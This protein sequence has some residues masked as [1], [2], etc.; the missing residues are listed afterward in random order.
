MNILNIQKPMCNQKKGLTV[1]SSDC[2]KKA[3]VG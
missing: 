2:I 1:V 3:L